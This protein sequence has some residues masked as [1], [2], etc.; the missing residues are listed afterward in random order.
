MKER[1]RYMS[2]SLRDTASVYRKAISGITTEEQ[3]WMYCADTT[4]LFFPMPV[5][6]L[7]VKEAF[8][9]ENKKSVRIFAVR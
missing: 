3:R 1:N 9:E 7:Y 2:K 6:S 5:G 4:N 8:P